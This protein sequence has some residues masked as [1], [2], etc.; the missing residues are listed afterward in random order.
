MI[1]RHAVPDRILVLD[2]SDG[3]AMLYLL[4]GLAELLRYGDVD[5]SQL[6]LLTQGRPVPGHDGAHRLAE[7]VDDAAAMIRT[8]LGR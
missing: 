6:L 8:Q 2:E 4:D 3:E 7:V 1:G 5:R